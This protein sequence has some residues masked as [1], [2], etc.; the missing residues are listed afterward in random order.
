M[1]KWLFLL[2]CFS[3][4][5][6]I[7]QSQGPDHILQ[8]IP[9]KLVVLTFDDGVSTHATYVAPLLKKYGFGGSFYVCEFPPDFQDKH[10]YMSWEQIRQLHDMGFEV[11][12]HTGRH[13]HL[14]E[15]EGP[16]IVRELE[17]IEDR[18]A[19]YG[20]PTP[21]TFAYPA[22]Y[23]NPEAVSILAD[24]GYTFARIG[25]A[26]PYD[27]R[28]DHPYFIPSYSTTGADKLRVL[29]AI[30]EAKDGKIVVL[31]VH[32]VPDYAH[33]WVTTPRELFEAY[34]QYLRDHQYTVI[35]L[36]DLEKYI[37][38][39]RARSNITP[40]VVDPK[41]QPVSIPETISIHIDC[42]REIGDMDPVYA[43]FGHDEPNYTYMKNGRKL[44]SELAGLSPVPVYVRTH[45]LLTTGDGQPALKWGST[46]AYTE[47]ADGK[48]IYDWTIVDKIFDTYVERSMK[49]L[50]EIGFMPKALSS[51][52]EPYRHNWAP[53]NPYGNIYTGWAHPPE[54]YEKWAELVYQWV[55]HAVDR[56]GKEEVETWYWEPWNE[57]NIGY[58]QGTTEEYLKL[59]DYTAD[60]VKRALPTAIIGGP[61]STGPSWDRAAAFL[62]TFLQHCSKGKNYATGATGSP[63]DFIAFHAKGGPKFIDDH[64]Q[65]N[66]GTQLRDVSRGFEIVAA[67]PEWKALP[68]VIGESDPEGCAAC[69]MDVYPHNGYRNGTMYSSYTAA[70]FARKMAL[71][72]HFGINF[73][74]AVT[75]AFEFEDQ[76][77]FHGFRDLATNGVDK[78]VLN[79]FRMFGMMSGKRVEVRGNMAYDYLLVRD[80]S[81]RGEQTDVNALAT[82]DE[83]QAAVLVWNYHD[84]DRSGP[85]APVQMTISGLPAGK[86]YLEHYRV[87]HTHSNAYTAWKNLGSPPYPTARQYAE[88]EKAGQL[89]LLDNPKWLTVEWDG[90][91][92]EIAL[93]RQGVSL[94]K[95]SW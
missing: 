51:K 23:T 91:E 8:P 17:Y 67:F 73:K 43:W 18:C 81:V 27:P 7:L 75:W 66:M 22:Y 94:L 42:D 92:M 5:V 32:G 77:W 13:T 24:K 90:L 12:N 21:Q 31:T 82:K 36:A 70:A 26:R 57:P 45:N 86:V 3:S 20:I 41:G 47:D 61:H 89:E 2:L 54:D 16:E 53:G 38:P 33:D 9:D 78:P 46:N 76:P 63:L 1:K 62:E 39:V 29:K 25:G 74:G 14:N 93:P 15:I 6:P 48:P 19:Q 85:A 72:D 55:Q 28:V 95:F 71:A 44:L 69:S 40:K 50:V 52:P 30:Q 10:K 49:P 56:Y 59:Y 35:G 11:A 60:A 83:H 88:L 34:L 4:F 80:S 64:V 84:D 79:V 68:I 37:D 58:W 87:D 65:M